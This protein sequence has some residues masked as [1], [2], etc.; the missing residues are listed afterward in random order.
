MVGT[1]GT[2]VERAV[3]QTE[4]PYLE[5]VPQ[6]LLCLIPYRQRVGRPADGG[7]QHEDL[8]LRFPLLAAER[9]EPLHQ[10]RR[11]AAVGDLLVC[12]QDLGSHEEVG[13]GPCPFYQRS[14]YKCTSRLARREDQ[15]SR[16]GLRVELALPVRDHPAGIAVQKRLLLPEEPQ[17]AHVFQV[18]AGLSERDHEEDRMEMDC[19]VFSGSLRFPEVVLCLPEVV[20]RLLRGH[21]EDGFRSL[22]SLP[23]H[24][25]KSSAYI[26]RPF[27]GA[28]HR[29]PL[30]ISHQHI[31]FRT[32][33]ASRIRA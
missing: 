12:V 11:A 26:P 27:P 28:H 23:Q 32:S 20:P 24:L 4:S 3:L 21:E 30:W 14:A 16:D 10:I 7:V 29:Q 1:A 15:L 13:Q 2:V 5:V 6:V 22:Q 8:T 31:P 19:R 18:H 9:E 25:R 17:Q 33:S